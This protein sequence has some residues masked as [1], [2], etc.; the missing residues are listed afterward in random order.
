MFSVLT[1]LEDDVV[2]EALKSGLDLRDYSKQVEEKLK[3]VENEAV[4]DC[5]SQVPQAVNDYFTL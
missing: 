3:N 2:K 1:H 5:K 4:Q